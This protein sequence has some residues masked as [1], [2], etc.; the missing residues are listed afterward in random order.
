MGLPVRGSS[1]ENG[2]LLHC[3]SGNGFDLS[4]AA[5]AAGMATLNEIPWGFGSADRQC[6]WE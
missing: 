4:K 6:L 2:S 1:M 3:I 5:V